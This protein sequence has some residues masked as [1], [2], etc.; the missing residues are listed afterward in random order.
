MKPKTLLVMRHAKSSWKD[1]TLEDHDRPLKKRRR[2]AAPRMGRLLTGE[3]LVAEGLLTSTALRAAETAR[4]VAKAC[5]YEGPIHA[6]RE[7]Y[8][9]G[10]GSYVATVKRLGG[11]AERVLVVGHNPDLEDLVE[12]L[13]GKRIE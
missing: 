5:G 13:C 10:P 2:K 8:L 11:D 7:L 9:G 4:A 1:S 12:G 3:S 6:L